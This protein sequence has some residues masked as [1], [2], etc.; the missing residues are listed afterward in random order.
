M[1]T[2]ITV[3]QNRSVT[4]ERDD[5]FSGERVERTYFVGATS[6][7]GYVHYH[8]AN[9]GSSQICEGM[10]GSGNTLMASRESLPAVLRQ[11]LRKQ[12]AREKRDGFR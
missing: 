6:G 4:V 7:L 1:K 2:K 3:N 8:T 10:S 12:N 11:E 5:V 9:G